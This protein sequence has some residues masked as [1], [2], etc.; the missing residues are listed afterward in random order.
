MKKNDRKWRENWLDHFF[1]TMAPMDWN[2]TGNPLH[3]CDYL[4]SY[5]AKNR[6]GK[7]KEKKNSRVLPPFYIAVFSQTKVS[8]IC[9]Y[10]PERRARKRKIEKPL[11]Q[12]AFLLGSI[13]RTF[14]AGPVKKRPFYEMN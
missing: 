10:R 6:T 13:L 4:K 14:R 3:C 11:I 5:G 7:R 1:D 8:T 12:G 2:C 9:E